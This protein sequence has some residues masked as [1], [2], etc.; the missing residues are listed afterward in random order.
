VRA[1]A[2][3]DGVISAFAVRIGT[4][5]PAA[6]ARVRKLSDVLGRDLADPLVKLSLQVAVLALEPTLL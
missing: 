1:F 4:S 5:R 3:A 2:E 6:Y